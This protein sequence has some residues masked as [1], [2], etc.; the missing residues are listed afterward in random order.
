MKQL[1]AMVCVLFLLGCTQKDTGTEVTVTNPGEPSIVETPTEVPS[2][3]GTE[4]PVITDEEEPP[5]LTPPQ[6]AMEIVKM[7]DVRL[8][9]KDLNITAG[10]T[11]Q[12]VHNDL[13]NENK[14]IIHQVAIYNNNVASFYVRS[15]NLRF[16]D[17]FNYTF[18]E[19][20]N[21]WFI[22]IIFRDRMKGTVIV[23]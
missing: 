5:Q 20:G 17:S 10:T 6:A 19:P 12:W 11:V 16:G 15:N 23:R 21:Y 22:D 9:P 14:N 2:L 7:E 8:M 13:Y 18:T 3:N 4:E 1:I